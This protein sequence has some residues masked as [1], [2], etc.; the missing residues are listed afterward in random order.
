MRYSDAMC[1]KTIGGY[2]VR[3]TR[4]GEKEV[5]F[6]NERRLECEVRW[7]TSLGIASFCRLSIL[8]MKFWESHRL[9][10]RMFLKHSEYL[11]DELACFGRRS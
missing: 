2:A 1:V 8:L 6:K 9:L 10:T 11:R 5:C 3:W 4:E 7:Q